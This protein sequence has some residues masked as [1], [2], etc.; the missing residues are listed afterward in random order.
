ME[1]GDQNGSNYL[2]LLTEEEYLD[3]LDATT[4]NQ[5]LD[6]TDHEIHR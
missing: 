1:G 5:Q 4:E 3:I 2:D 6:D